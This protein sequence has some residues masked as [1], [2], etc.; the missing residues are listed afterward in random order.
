[1]GGPISAVGSNYIAR[2][3]RSQP[4]YPAHCDGQPNAFARWEPGL[5]QSAQV[6]LLVEPGRGLV[7]GRGSVSDIDLSP[8]NA[9]LVFPARAEL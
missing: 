5:R 6:A 8:A 3:V 7:A 2:R 9:E 1:M 4:R